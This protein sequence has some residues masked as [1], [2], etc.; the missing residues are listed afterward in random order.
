M[1][2]P[3]CREELEI[4]ESY[5]KMHYWKQNDDDEWFSECNTDYGDETYVQCSNCMTHLGEMG[6]DYEFSDL[7][8]KVTKKD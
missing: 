8:I 7:G 5:W 6:L 1:K 3:N 2:C 4:V